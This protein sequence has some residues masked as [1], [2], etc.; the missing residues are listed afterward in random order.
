VPLTISNGLA[1][2]FFGRVWYVLA[3]PAS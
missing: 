1:G 2:E 3:R